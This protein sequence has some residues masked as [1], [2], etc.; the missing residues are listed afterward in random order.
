MAAPPIA[1]RHLPHFH[2]RQPIKEPVRVATTG[3][4]TIATALNVGDSIDGVTL[5]DGD[6]VLVKSQSTVSQNGLYVAGA[7]PV[8]AYDQSTDDPAFAFLVYVMAGTV[9]GGTLWKNTNTSVPTIDTTALTFSAAASP[10]P[11]LDDLTDVTI[12][13]VAADDTLQY[14]GSGWVNTSRRWEPVTFDPGT[15]PEIV[16][17]ATDIVMTWETY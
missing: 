11:A 10:N 8:R 15:G 1:E 6:R 12:T 16:F 17:T 9:N 13:A 7:T 2:R 3:N 5:A 4:I 14:D